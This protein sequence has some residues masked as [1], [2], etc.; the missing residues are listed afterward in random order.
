MFA[1][2]RGGAGGTLWQRLIH[3]SGGGV[4]LETAATVTTFLLAGRLYEARA[5]ASEEAIARLVRS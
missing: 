4:Y 1:L 5:G 3:N 2:D